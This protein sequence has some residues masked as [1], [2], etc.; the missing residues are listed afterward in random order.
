MSQ[1]SLLI[2]QCLLPLPVQAACFS[3]Q[4]FYSCGTVHAKVYLPLSGSPSI[5]MHPACTAMPLNPT[6]LDLGCLPLRLT[7]PL[8]HT[9]LKWKIVL[10]VRHSCSLKPWEL[11]TWFFTVLHCVFRCLYLDKAGITC[12]YSRIKAVENR[13]HAIKSL[14]TFYRFWPVPSLNLLLTKLTAASAVPTCYLPCLLLYRPL[15]ISNFPPP[16]SNQR[17]FWTSLLIQSITRPWFRNKDHA[18]YTLAPMHCPSKDRGPA[19]H[20]SLQAQGIKLHNFKQ[21]D[22][23]L[24]A[25][26]WLGKGPW[27][28]T[29]TCV[30]GCDLQKQ[31]LTN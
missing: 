15:C 3:L 10:Q 11:Q 21:H 7:F 18:D 31:H 27:S 9:P 23:L 20:F 25:E 14:F 28:L 17:A 2:S 22:L 16:N 26:R 30:L 12:Y 19:W 13:V 1:F 24:G 4:F 6:Q 8:W 5:P 29:C